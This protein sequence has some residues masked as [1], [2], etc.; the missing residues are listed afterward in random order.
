MKTIAYNNKKLRI[1]TALAAAFFIVFHGRPLNLLKAFTSLSFYTAVTVSFVISLLLVYT[2]HIV[3]IWLD[4]RSGWRLEPV[5]RSLLQFLLGVLLPAVT[6]VLLISSYFELLGQNI[7]DNGFLLVDFPVIVFFIIFLNLY[8]V[9]HYLLLSD[10]KTIPD[11]TK[12]VN[13]YDE[14]IKTKKLTVDNSGLYLEFDVQQEILYFYRFR[15]HVKFTAFNG[16][17]YSFKETLGS[18]AEQFKDCSF[19][20]INRSVVLNFNIVEDYQPGLKRNTLEIIFENKYFNLLKN[21]NMDRFV[22]TKE[23]ISKVSNYFNNI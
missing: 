11:Y 7:F 22:V 14:N 2:I 5:K 16:E 17:E 21:E 19:I 13:Q 18:A 4:K 23:H 15:K 20:Q 12:E 6:D 8:Y 9:I 3:T 1:I 10:S